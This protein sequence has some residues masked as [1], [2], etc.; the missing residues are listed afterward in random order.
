[1]NEF[2]KAQRDYAATGIPQVEAGGN[3]TFVI[4]WGIEPNIVDGEQQ[5]VKC[6]AKWFAGM[7][8]LGDLVDAMVHV[9]YSVSDELALLRQR[10]VKADEFA[11]YNTF[12]EACKAEAK[13]VLGIENG[14][15]E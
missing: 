2:G 13:V 9:K 14:E 12:V 8:T 7:P 5:G 4:R 11:E 3:N 15:Q 1:M 6:W 10:D